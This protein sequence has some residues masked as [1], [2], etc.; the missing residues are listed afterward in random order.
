MI[1]IID[2][3]DSFTYNL[4][5]YYRQLTDTVRVIRVNEV[6]IEQ[7]AQ[8][9]PSLIVISPGPGAPENQPVCFDILDHFHPTTPI[10]GVC[11]GMQMMVHYFDGKVS[12][13]TAPMHGKTSVISHTGTGVFEGVPNQIRV[14]RYHSLVTHY[15]PEQFDITALT[16]SNEIMGIKHHHFQVEG[17][18]FHPEAILTEYGFDMIRNSFNQA[19]ER[20]T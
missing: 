1:V 9:K 8:M 4:A 10:F 19:M 12:K 15:I 17:I 18:Q 20:Y 2:N 5:Q 13:A 14:T 3:Y 7:L 16:S 6:T 11:L